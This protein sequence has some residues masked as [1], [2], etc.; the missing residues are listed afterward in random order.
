MYHLLETSAI[1][2]KLSRAQISTIAGLDDTYCILG[3]AEAC[4]IRLTKANGRR[5]ALVKMRQ[6]ERYK[7]F[8]LTRE[9]AAIRAYAESLA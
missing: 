1:Y 3:C 4:A 5:P 8:A 9:G 2:G 6:G 7:E